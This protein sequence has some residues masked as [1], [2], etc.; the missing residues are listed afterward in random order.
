MIERELPGA[1]ARSEEELRDVSLRS[2]AALGEL[3]ARSYPQPPEIFFF[4]PG[5]AA[6]FFPDLSKVGW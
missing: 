2:T 4:P 3:G 5:A 1:G 6:A